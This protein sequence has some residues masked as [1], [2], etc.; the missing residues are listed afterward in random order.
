MASPKATPPRFALLVYASAWIKH[1]Y[2][3]EFACALINSQP[4][5]FYAP[6]QIVRD[7]KAHGVTVLP[8]DVN[9]STW[10]C[11]DRERPRIANIGTVGW[12]IA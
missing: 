2:P 6:A 4:M 11:T 3:A 9:H 7:A 12:A 5:G 10:D 8:P 1:Y